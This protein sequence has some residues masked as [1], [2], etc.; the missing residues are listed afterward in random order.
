MEFWSDIDRNYIVY[1]HNFQLAQTLCSHKLMFGETTANNDRKLVSD[2]NFRLCDVK[3][4]MLLTAV[5]KA[6]VKT[7]D[8][9][10]LLVFVQWLELVYGFVIRMCRWENSLMMC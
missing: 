1:Y 10:L 4:V 5:W 6:K 3:L 8:K 7:M 2:C 9:Y